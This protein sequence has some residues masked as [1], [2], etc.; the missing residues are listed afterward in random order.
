MIIYIQS[1]ARR[2]ELSQP[3]WQRVGELPSALGAVRVKQNPLNP[4]F[5]L[6]GLHRLPPAQATRALRL[7]AG[8]STAPAVPETPLTSRG[9]S[10]GS[11]RC[12]VPES[13]LTPPGRDPSAPPTP[14]RPVP[15]AET[16]LTGERPSRAL[17]PSLAPRQRL[18]EPLSTSR[19]CP[20]PSLVR[21]RERRGP[22]RPP[23]AVAALPVETEPAPVRRFPPPEGAGGREARGP[24]GRT[25]G[26]PGSGRGRGSECGT[27]RAFGAPARLCSGA[28]SAALPVQSGA[29]SV[30]PPVQSGARSVALP[31]QSGARSVAERGS[32]CGTARAERGSE[33]G[34]ARAER[35]SER[36]RA[37]LGVWH[38][39]CR[40]GLGAW[41]SGARSVA[42][43]VQSGARSVALPVQSGAR[44]VAERGSECGTA[45][46]E[47][48]SECGT[49]R[50]ERG[51]ERGTARAERGSE[52]GTPPVPSDTGTALQLYQQRTNPLNDEAGVFWEAHPPQVSAKQLST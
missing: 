19:H 16:H 34:T 18:P 13:H 29:R 32:E 25:A 52:R 30:A 11:P 14:H 6:A 49:A 21:Y 27:A 1:P 31:A 51:S 2:R 39:P 41:Q 43:P 3:G 28:R 50:A 10:P 47:R 15:S 40:A 12:P 42:L 22:A 7:T 24:A 4:G 35:G 8:V 5:P 37:G 45:R 9:K 20:D 46:A 33:R 26:G 48:G 36:G 23:P 44:S 38:C 17:P